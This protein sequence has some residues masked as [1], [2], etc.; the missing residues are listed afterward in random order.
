M[1]RQSIDFIKAMVASERKDRVTE[2]NQMTLGELIAKLEGI[3]IR[4]GEDEQSVVFDF[5]DTQPTTLSSWRGDY[6]E[7]AIGWTYRG[8]SPDGCP[9]HNGLESVTLSG[10]ISDLREAV[11]STYMGWKGGDF[12]MGKSTP[13]WVANDGNSG[14]TGIADVYDDGWRVVLLT[15]YFEY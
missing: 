8:Y 5:G 2:S 15:K 12:L 4:S 1:T 14:N 13:I 10:F 9:D 6:S 11:G 7:L 3:P